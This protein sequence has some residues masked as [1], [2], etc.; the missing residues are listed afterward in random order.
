MT[1]WLL[2]CL[3][4]A[5]ALADKKVDIATTQL[6][7]LKTA[8]KCADK[9]SVWR[10][11][12]SPADFFTGAA[13]DLPKGKVLVGLTIELEV[14]KDAVTA[15]RDNVSFTALAI[16]A[17]GK[18]KLTMVKPTNKEE[19]KATMEAVMATSALFK[20]KAKTAKVPKDLASYAKTL[21]GKYATKK[22]GSDWTW[23]GASA[24]RLRKVGDF[25]VV[26]EVPDKNN[27]VWA[28]VLTDKWE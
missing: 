12:C 15:L 18:A 23:K 14:G 17:D 8:A 22:V 10:T 19:E 16:D 2:L 6:A 1:K 9:A 28:T 24:T 4:A 5:P 25:W 13:G 27:G 7:A 26:I 3:L 21:K 20:G 11:W